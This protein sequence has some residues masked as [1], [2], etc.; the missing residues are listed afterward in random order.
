[1]HALYIHVCKPLNLSSIYERIYRWFTPPD[2][3]SVGREPAKF[4]WSHPR[5]HQPFSRYSSNRV[6]PEN[7]GTCVG[8]KQARWQTSLWVSSSSQRYSIDFPLLLLL[9]DFHRNR[10]P[11]LRVLRQPREAFFPSHGL[12]R[13]VVVSFWWRTRL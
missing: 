7:F 12:T 8:A 1:M 2:S 6:R 10:S 11:D 13:S 5:I 3:P 9:D 4:A